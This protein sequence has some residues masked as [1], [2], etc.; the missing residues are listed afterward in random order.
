[1]KVAVTHLKAPWPAGT[2]PGDVVELAVDAIPGWAE[3]K[4]TPAADDAEVTHS[5]APA[6]PVLVVNPA[7]EGDAEAAK[8]AAA[9]ADAEA[10]HQ[11]EL[12]DA[13]A[14]AKADAEA[15]AKPK[16]KAAK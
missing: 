8:I 13:E 11:Q 1:M 14:R 15:A 10:Q 2:V 6:A 9:L 12:A 16:G 5:M 4:C 7:G 3:G